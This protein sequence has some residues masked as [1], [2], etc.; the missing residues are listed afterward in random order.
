MT[1]KKVFGFLKKVL[2]DAKH[3][4]NPIFCK[5]SQ[6]LEVV[7][8]KIPNKTCYLIFCN[9]FINHLQDEFTTIDGIRFL[10]ITKY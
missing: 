2:H 6:N 4:K 8:K 1:P 5:F 7:K 9:Y 3:H 10:V